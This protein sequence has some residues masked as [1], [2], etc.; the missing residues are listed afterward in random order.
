MPRKHGLWIIKSS[1]TAYQNPW[2]KLREDAVIQPNGQ[3]SVHVVIDDYGGA[4]VLAMDKDGY[5]YLADEFK[6]GLGR[7]DLNT[8]TGGINPKETPLQAA[9]RELK[10]E[11]GITAKKWTKLG[12]VHCYT[13]ISNSGS[14][15]Y[16]A[17]DLSFGQTEHEGTETIQV[18]KI[19]FDQAVKMVLADKITHAPTVV[20]ILK[21]REFL[22]KDTRRK[23]Q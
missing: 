8:A 20:A 18:R 10:E 19:K 2:F 5:V 7:H 17:Q 15:L 3:H 22:K 23:K 16:L 1:R 14:Y 21:A 13:S 6:Y 11:L 12:I 9:K 4:N